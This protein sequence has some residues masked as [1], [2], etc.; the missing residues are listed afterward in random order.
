[1]GK[2]DR[3]KEENAV[4]TLAAP[5]KKKSAKAGMP[6]WVGT[7]ILVSVLVLLVV[8]VT[9][10]VLSS[11]GTFKRMHVIAESENFEVTVPMMSYL[12]YTE[13]QNLVSTY[14]NYSQQFGTTISIPAADSTGTALDKNK[15]LREQNY[16]VVTNDDG[17]TTAV[18][19]FDRFAEL[20]KN[21]LTEILASCEYALA[22]NISLDEAEQEAIDMSIDNL[23]LYASYYG[24]T[25]N[26]YLASMYGEGVMKKDVRAMMELTEL[27][28]K[29]SELRS[30][31][32]LDAVTDAAVEEKY[33][34]DVKTYDTYI[35]Y[36]GYTFTVEFEPTKLVDGADEKNA[37]LS[38]KYEA[39][40]AKVA[41]YIAE[42][43]AC[44]TPT[45]FSTKLLPILQEYF[46]E[47]EKENLLAKKAEGAELTAEE[48]KT[49]QSNADTRATKAVADATQIN[50]NTSDSSINVDVKDWLADTA[51]PR[52]ANDKKTFITK[53][54]AYGN[55]ES[56]ED[57]TST[58]YS[59]AESSYGIYMTM[60]A[61][62]RNSG[63]VRSVG[64]ILF[65]NDTFKNV[66]DTSKLTASQKVLAD[67]ILARG[68]TISAKEMAAEL[69]TLMKEEGKLTQN[70]NGLWMME[71]AVFEAYGATYTEDSNVFY[72]NVAK[73][74]MVESF[75][76]WMFDAARVE[77]E[78]SAEAVETTYGYH[79]MLYRA[80]E[81][82]AWSYDIRN[83]LAEDSYEAWLKSA[84]ET[85]K[86]TFAEDSKYW[87]MITG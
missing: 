13:Y 10:S 40:K 66:T 41:A 86:T 82:P 16:K 52:K 34:S 1:M 50:H 14:D 4:N 80:D 18:T 9:L 55:D 65:K 25:M 81:K 61:L 77:G 76:N 44:A 37:A 21:D 63:V 43:E 71:E 57:K 74:Q 17:T 84:T 62:H 20:A 26:A 54:D 45:E 27:A 2:S 12:V 47:E 48:L 29:C 60:S 64:H 83:E 69:I 49:C 75:E 46:L 72:D 19:W 8:V 35:D 42:L 59:E 31:E 11:R 51:E 38:E 87:N 33:S 70:S 28:N 78:V 58:T 5:A 56:K 39:K 3:I 68:A 73:G 67:R 85:Y 30:K 32:L 79:V 36:I 7:A 23:E 24:Y 6:T 15:P 53:E 22:N